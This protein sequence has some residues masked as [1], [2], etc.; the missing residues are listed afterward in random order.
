MTLQ[1]LL[2]TVV[3]ALSVL[4]LFVA[5]M[6]ANEAM[7]RRD[8][9]L[10]VAETVADT[11][12]LLDSAM[13]LV[14]ERDIVR[15]A[16]TA[17]G[18][19]HPADIAAMKES[20]AKSEQGFAESLEHIRDEGQFAGKAQF[21][22]AFEEAHREVAELRRQA[23][24]VMAKGGDETDFTLAR[25]WSKAVTALIDRAEELRRA[26]T[27]EA[28]EADADTASHSTLKHLVLVMADYAGR[29]RTMLA[30]YIADD[31]P[32]PPGRLQQIY[33]YRGRVDMAWETLRTGAATLGDAATDQAIETAN[34][35]FIEAF[36]KTREAV[37]RAGVSA[38]QYP[39]DAAGW[40]DAS[41]AGIATIESIEHSIAAVNGRHTSEMA[42]EALSR[43]VL[44]VVLLGF[45]L[46]TAV[47]SFFIVARLVVGPLKAMTVVMTRLAE[48]DK[49]VDIPATGKKNEIGDMAKAVLVF[50]ENMIRND[51]MLAEQEAER[52]TKEKRT[53]RVAELT[54]GFDAKARDVLQTVASAATELQQTAETMA[55]TAE[56]TNQQAT[57]VATASN[58]ATANVQTVATASEELSASISEIGRQV[59]QSAKIAANAVEEAAR[60]NEAVRGLDE[61]ANKIGE[62][63][64]L[65]NDIA[66]QTNLLA[67]NATIEAA[68]AGEAGKG[69]AVVAQE[70]KNL[71]NQTAKATEEISAQISSVQE[72]TRDTVTAIDNIM[73][74]I[75]E[76]SDISTTIASAVEEQGVSTQEI[77]RNVQQAAQGTQEVN[78]NIAGVTQAASSTGAASS[79]VLDSASQLS[80]QAEG[81]RGDV[82]K[83]LAD[84]R[85][86]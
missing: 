23:D 60:T 49:S 55:A 80:A 79:Q 10:D 81:L 72:E 67:L 69:F 18:A 17:P 30:E 45:G 63:V 42:G 71:A 58:Q 65:I 76:I 61:A 68:R 28:A 47:A 53:E 44:L 66:G 26:K 32:L 84:V 41:T 29:E 25:N 9:A 19:V 40:F 78:T 57:A 50:K 35:Q 73:Q 20:R 46:V 75:N 77:A 24:A 34:A 52:A 13:L 37:L 14:E 16:L 15:V 7:D 31:M 3:G 36:G 54:D 62:V 8:L 12:I 85:A 22:G 48:G 86:A 11:E 74:V 64:T 6:S 33:G 2:F 39:V 51:E 82:E 5:G 27:H 1:K 70:V 38:R 83:F 43:L 21:V 59:N 56:Q 4:L